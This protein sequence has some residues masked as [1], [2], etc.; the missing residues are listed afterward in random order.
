MGILNHRVRRARAIGS[1]Y[2]S[3]G[4]PTILYASLRNSSTVSVDGRRDPGSGIG[5]EECAS[6]R[7]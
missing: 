5:G 7:S 6:V 1:A 2:T 3:K 4:R